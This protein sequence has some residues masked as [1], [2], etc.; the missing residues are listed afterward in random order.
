[1]VL[2]PAAISLHGSIWDALALDPASPDPNEC[3]SSLGPPPETPKLKEA[4]ISLEDI[5]KFVAAETTVL[6]IPAIANEAANLQLAL[7]KFD[8]A[9]AVQSMSKLSKLLKPING[10]D[11]F[12]QSRQEER[13]R[14]TTLKLEKA[15]SEGTK[16]IYFID[17]YIKANLGDSKTSSLMKLR[18]QIADSISKQAIERINRANNTLQDY[19]KEQR[20]ESSYRDIVR[21]FSTPVPTPTPDT[22]DSLTR[23]LG[24]SERSTYVIEGPADHNVLIYNTSPSA[25]RIWKNVRGNFVFQEEIASLCFGQS[26]PDLALVRYVERILRHDGAKRVISGPRPCDL[27]MVGSSIDII[28]FQRGGLLKERENYIAALVK[29]IEQNAFRQY[30]IVTNYSNEQQ[31][32]EASVAPNRFGPRKEP[33]GG[34]W[35]PYGE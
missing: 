22:A 24:V 14:G 8:E 16:N 13:Q 30:N 3:I 6:P 25:P 34:V 27:S 29:V 32:R 23:R 15:T 11:A 5:Q 28:A 33:T 35:R 1:L 31:T 26:S 2:A 21:D 18:Q 7:N 4:R 12:L 17:R 10:F 19:I 9:G 20:L